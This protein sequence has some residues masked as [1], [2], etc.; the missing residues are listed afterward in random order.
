M[1]ATQ[2]TH[3]IGQSV[4]D[5]EPGEE[6][7]PPTAHRQPLLAGQSRPGGKAARLQA[8]VWRGRNAKHAGGVEI[9]AEDSGDAM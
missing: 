4:E 5:K 7:M 3:E 8:S 6:K 9:V 1:A 2:T